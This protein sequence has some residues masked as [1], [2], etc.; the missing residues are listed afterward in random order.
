MNQWLSAALQQSFL[1]LIIL[2][3]WILPRGTLRHM[4]LSNLLLV[5]IGMAADILEFISESV[6]IDSVRCDRRLIL[7]ILSV[8]SWS[9]FQF[10]F[11]CFS[12]ISDEIIVQPGENSQQKKAW[13]KRCLKN[14]DVWGS[15]C[16]CVL[17]D[18]PYL[19]VRLYLCAY[20]GSAN[21]SQVFFIAKNL[22]VLLLQFY[23]LWALVKTWEDDE[24]RVVERKFKSIR[25]TMNRLRPR[26]SHPSSIT[27]R[28]RTA[29]TPTEREHT[30]HTFA[31][32]SYRPNGSLTPNDRNSLQVPKIVCESF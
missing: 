10:P 6:V 16:T 24:G 4:D 7:L 32:D 8:W 30:F 12:K 14:P 27:S 31:L 13:C 2:G 22:M 18:G 20:I 5:H 19:V 17:Q 29:V 25:M 9:L 28:G 3:R 21:Q 26:S 1:I 23:R 11:H 15:I